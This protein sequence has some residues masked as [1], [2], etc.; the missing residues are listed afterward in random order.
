MPNICF[1][2]PGDWPFWHSLDA[3]ISRALFLRK[4]EAGECYIVEAD[5]APAGLLRWNRFWDEVPFCTLLY[6][7]EK[8]RGQG[9]GRALVARWEADMRGMGHGMAMTSTQSDEDAQY[10]WRALGY[11]DAG[12]FDIDVPGYAQPP[13][14]IMLKDLRVE[15]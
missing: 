9:L 4:A 2:T 11:R 5:G 7:D 14:L 6:I 8:R 13:E 12:S 10:F 1:A 15:R 3:R